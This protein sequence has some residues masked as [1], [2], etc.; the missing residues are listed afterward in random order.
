MA[1]REEERRMREV[2]MTL[3][4]DQRLAEEQKRR[5]EERVKAMEV[6]EVEVTADPGAGPHIETKKMKMCRVRVHHTRDSHYGERRFVE[7][8]ERAG[9]QPVPWAEQVLYLETG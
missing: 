5:Y 3:A 6:E 4:R 9:L 1:C 8:R 2:A 7:S